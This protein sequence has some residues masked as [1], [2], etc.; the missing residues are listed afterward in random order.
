MICKDL[1]ILLIKGGGVLNIFS[2]KTKIVSGRTSAKYLKELGVGRLL[3]VTDPYFMEKGVAETLVRNSG[4]DKWE[5]FHKVVP[6][7]TVELAAEG[8]AVLRNFQPDTVVALGGGSAMDCAKAM[9]YFSKMP[10]RFVAIPTTSGSGSEVTD[11]AI[12]THENVKHPLVS[13]RLCPDV[14]ILD[15]DFLTQLPRKLIADTG[16]DVIAHALEAYVAKDGGFFTDALAKEAFCVAMATLPASF[17]GNVGV[18]QRLHEASAMAGMAFTKAGLGLCHAMSHTLG[19]AFHISHGRLN[20]ILLPAVVGC[21]ANLCSDKY[22]RLA[23]E[24]G[25]SG[26][27]DAVA[28]RN[29]KNA[30]IRLRKELDMPQ[31][32]KEAGVDPRQVWHKTDALVASI[33]KDPCCKTNP[34]PVEGFMVRRILE[35]V[36]GRV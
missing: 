19:G 25:L 20:A 28:T 5:I 3:L 12:L 26:A 29:L 13:E 8:T 7:P 35:E 24:A 33:L 30:L 6:D 32:L 27:A 23:R 10:L 21:N 31:T 16:F 36:S 15:G 4:A 2:C 17:G 1:E 11:F 22:A 34:I 18:R 14:A 9:V